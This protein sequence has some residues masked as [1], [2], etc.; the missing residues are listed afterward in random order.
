MSPPQ[1]EHRAFGSAGSDSGD[2]PWGNQPEIRVR[3][4]VCK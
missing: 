2:H 1:V 3:S 4:A